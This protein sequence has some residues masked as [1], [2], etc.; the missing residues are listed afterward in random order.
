MPIYD[1]SIWHVSANRCRPEEL[2]AR[3]GAVPDGAELK[4]MRSKGFWRSV[5]G[6]LVFWRFCRFPT[7]RVLG[8]LAAL[9][10]A[11]YVRTPL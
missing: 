10:I 9:R 1:L 8:V 5:F 11:I 6:G 3:V 7:L 2:D 4:P